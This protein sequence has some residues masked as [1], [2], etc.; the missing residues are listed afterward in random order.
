VTRV[1]FSTAAA[2]MIAAGA[3][4]GLSAPAQA[5]VG[6]EIGPGGARVYEQRPRV[7]RRIIERRSPARRVVVEEDGDDEVCETRTAVSG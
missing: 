7:E 1:L 5:Q 6:V 2:V 4:V 3:G